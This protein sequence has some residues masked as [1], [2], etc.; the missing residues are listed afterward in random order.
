[1]ESLHL[2]TG[3]F[4]LPDFRKST[5]SIAGSAQKLLPEFPG[6][7]SRREPILVFDE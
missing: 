5:Y 2:K 7:L 4:H 6:I 3:F 1:M